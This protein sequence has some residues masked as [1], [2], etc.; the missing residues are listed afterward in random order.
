[1]STIHGLPSRLATLAALP[2]RAA[3][4][5]LAFALAALLGACGPGVG[6][7]GTGDATSI[8]APFGATA[9]SACGSDLAELLGCP[10]SGTPTTPTPDTAPQHLADSA[11]SPQVLVRLHGDTIELDAPCA[12]LRFRGLWGVVAGQAGRF[13]GVT[14]P[15][16]AQQPATLDAQASGPGVLVTVRDAEGHIVLGPVLLTVVAATAVPAACN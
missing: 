16:G 12:L 15:E 10:P 5:T 3:L 1:M 8:L 7:T 9:A 2:A 11:D 6:G 13:Y 4:A 14:G